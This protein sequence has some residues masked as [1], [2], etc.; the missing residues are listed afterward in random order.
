MAIERIWMTLRPSRPESDL[1]FIVDAA[2]LRLY[3]FMDA[4]PQEE[5]T[6]PKL[7]AMVSDYAAGH[8]WNALDGELLLDAVEEIYRLRTALAA[9]RADLSAAIDNAAA[10]AAS[11]GSKATARV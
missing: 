5:S 6:A 11:T 2:N 9:A 7:R 8:E 4:I 3:G 10:A 1:C